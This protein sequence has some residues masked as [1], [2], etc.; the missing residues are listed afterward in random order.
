MNN[1]QIICLITPELTNLEVKQTYK[2]LT[3][4]EKKQNK[5]LRYFELIE[6]KKLYSH[7]KILIKLYG[8]INDSNSD[9]L[10]KLSDRL[11]EKI[12]SAISDNSNFLMEKE[13]Y[14]E[15]F[16]KRQF[17]LKQMS[18]F[19]FLFVKGLPYSWLKK[20]LNN[21]IDL[22]IKYEFVEYEILLRRQLLHIYI[23]EKDDKMVEESLNRIEMNSLY[24]KYLI[25]SD[26]YIYQF[27][28]RVQHKSIDDRS[29]IE[30]IK[31]AVNEV[32]GFYSESKLNFL[33]YQ[34]LM[35]ELQLAHYE[36]D[37]V[38]AESVMFKLIEVTESSHS[39]RYLSRIAMNYMN[40]AYTQFF[41]HKFE[42]A[43][44]N[45]KKAATVLSSQGNELNIY[46]EASVFALIYLKRYKEAEEALQKILD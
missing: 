12:F 23:T 13:S 31:N 40:L 16:K 5:L 6:K 21:A 1:H 43:Y 33:L 44:E 18:L 25:R 36:E 19:Q 4:I 7:E 29:L 38:F 27:I 35:L 15:I 28:E 26:N 8:A 10:R 46:S 32:N 14:S 37:Y 11:I 9:S 2:L 34:K 3:N 22:C 24:F 42:E 45:S 30:G 39:V 41:L 20:L 17:A